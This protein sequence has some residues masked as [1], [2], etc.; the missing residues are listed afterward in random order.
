MPS[1]KNLILWGLTKCTFSF[2]IF[3]SLN[4]G[5]AYTGNIMLMVAMKFMSLVSLIKKVCN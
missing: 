2:K 1:S 4:D 5:I 3:Q